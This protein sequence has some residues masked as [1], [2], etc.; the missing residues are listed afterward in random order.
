MLPKYN[1]R[2]IWIV[3][4]I[5][6][7]SFICVLWVVKRKC[8]LISVI[9]KTNNHKL[10]RKL[11]KFNYNATNTVP[12]YVLITLYAPTVIFPLE[13]FRLGLEVVWGVCGIS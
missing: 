9:A 4:K 6:K 1:I 10:M 11:T 7:M 12:F 5:Y 13:S 2:N 8:R 3:L